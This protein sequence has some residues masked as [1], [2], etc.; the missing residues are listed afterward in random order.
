M[1]ATMRFTAGYRYLHLPA[2]VMLQVLHLPKNENHRLVAANWVTCQHIAEFRRQNF[3]VRSV[4][5][6]M[7]V[8]HGRP[9]TWWSI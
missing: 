7:L 8:C 5:D 2:S 4:T 6:C 9:I 3:Q 1:F